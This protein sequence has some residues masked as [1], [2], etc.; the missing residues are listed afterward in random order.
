[1]MGGAEDRQQELVTKDF[2]GDKKKVLEE[3]IHRGTPGIYICGAFQFLGKYYETADK[4]RLE[5]LDILPFYTESAKQGEKRLIGDIVVKLSNSDLLQNY[6]FNNAEVN[7]N[8]YEPQLLVGFENHGGRTFIDAKEK[9][10]G[11]PLKGFGNNGSKETEGYVYLNTLCTYLHG[12]LLPKNPQIT[13]FLL[14]KA[15][16]VKYNRPV[17]LPQAD[18]ELEN[19]ARA[20]LLKKLDVQI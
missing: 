14:E 7:K 6:P 1:M 9:A 16:Q 12:P 3:K 20:Y 5:C 15:L 10:L 2:L 4:H 18:N 13:D 11:K 19:K 17:S 8:Y